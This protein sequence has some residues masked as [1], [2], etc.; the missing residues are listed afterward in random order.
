MERNTQNVTKKKIH[1]KTKKQRIKYQ[2]KKS[3]LLLS[4]DSFLPYLT[5][6]NKTKYK[7]L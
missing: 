3:W 2:E 1:K 7:F 6:S 4:I 5:I